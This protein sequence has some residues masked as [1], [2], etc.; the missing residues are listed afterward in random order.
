[1]PIS[2]MAAFLKMPKASL[3]LATG[4]ALFG[5]SGCVPDRKTQAKG[6]RFSLLNRVEQA[7]KRRRRRRL[8]QQ[9]LNYK[10][11]NEMT[12]LESRSQF[13]QH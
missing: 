8:Q 11:K 10:K 5:N 4:K 6:S 13:A 7:G 3:S 12:E 9:L 2:R 1:M